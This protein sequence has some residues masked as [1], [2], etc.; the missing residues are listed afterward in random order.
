[1]SDERLVV[2]R[3]QHDEADGAIHRRLQQRRIGEREVIADEQRA[4]LRR[5]VVAS[6][7][8]DAIDRGSEFLYSLF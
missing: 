8:L 4:A 5:D 6:Q 7:N 2:H 3:F 1:M